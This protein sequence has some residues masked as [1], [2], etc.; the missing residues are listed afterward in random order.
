MNIAAIILAAGSSSRMKQSKQLLDIHGEQ[1]LAK[2]VQ[3]VLNA[4]IADVA[5]V[6]GADEEQHRKIIERLPVE[7]VFNKHWQR[8]MGSSLKAGLLHVLSQ[9]PSLDA[10]MVLVCDQPLLERGN[11]SGLVE[12]YHETGKPIIA[13]RYSGKPGVPALFDKSYFEQLA[14][15]ADDQ[16]AKKVILQNMEDVSEVDFPG[17]EVDL[18]T[19]ED[20]DAFLR[21][22]GSR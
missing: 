12:R 9:H 21:R 13:S 20:Y 17:G 15:L 14:R 6:L 16:G 11:I 19:R 4:G 10:V 7:T 18:D 5:V 22:K 1:L 8:G 3:A 2:T